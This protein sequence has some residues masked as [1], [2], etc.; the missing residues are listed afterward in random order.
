EEAHT[1]ASIPPLFCSHCTDHI[2]QTSYG[3]VSTWPAVSQASRPCAGERKCSSRSFYP[4][5][6]QGIFN[7]NPRGSPSSY[8]IFERISSVASTPGSLL[9]AVAGGSYCRAAEAC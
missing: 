4:A 2:R 3:E 1:E 6:D 9:V 8:R 5:K 7:R